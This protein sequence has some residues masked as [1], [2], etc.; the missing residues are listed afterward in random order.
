MFYGEF[1]HTVDPKGR[2]IIPAA[3]RDE[4]KSKFMVTKGLEGC[5]FI[6]SMPKWDSLVEKIETLPLSN[7]KAREFSR[8]FFSSAAQCELD[9]HSR[10]LVP[11]DLRSHAGLE[12]D[13]SI[14][15]VG[16]RVEVWNKDRWKE[17]MDGESLSPE[18]LSDTFALLG[19]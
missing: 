6:F 7:N 9:K 13:I 5:L 12:K 2:I 8:F 17:Y 18:S 3:F 15:G 11:Q 1:Q 4:L 19:I 14:V 10:I 16:N